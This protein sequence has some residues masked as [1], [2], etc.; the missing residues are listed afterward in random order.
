M[1]IQQH[2]YDKLCMY[3]QQ[4]YNYD[5][6]TSYAVSKAFV[7]CTENSVLEQAAYK[8]STLDSYISSQKGTQCNYSSTL[9][10]NYSVYHTHVRT[11]QNYKCYVV[12]KLQTVLQIITLNYRQNCAS[13]QHTFAAQERGPEG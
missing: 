12:H 10:I 11:T 7:K 9:Y 2:Y 6:N 8:V 3:Q 5:T 4:Q 13:V 1:A